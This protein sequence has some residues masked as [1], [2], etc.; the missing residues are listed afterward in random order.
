MFK[1]YWGYKRILGVFIGYK[2]CLE[3]T[4]GV[5]R[6]QGVLEDTRVIREY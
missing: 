2:G 3:D 4:R 5:Y 1:G 6:I